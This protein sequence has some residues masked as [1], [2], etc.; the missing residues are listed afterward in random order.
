MQIWKTAKQ[1]FGLISLSL[2]NT[3][4]KKHTRNG[5]AGFQKIGRLLNHMIE[6]PEKYLR[7]DKS[8]NEN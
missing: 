6:N 5:I 8:F 4:M 1:A 2:V 7:K 3:L